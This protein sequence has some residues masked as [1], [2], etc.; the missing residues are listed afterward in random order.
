MRSR[1]SASYGTGTITAVEDY[2]G[3][4]TSERGRCHRLVYGEGDGHP[5]NCP[6]PPVKSGWRQS[7]GGSWHAVD[8]CVRHSPELEDRPR[9]GRRPAA[10]TASYGGPDVRADD[11]DS[12]EGRSRLDAPGR[13][14]SRA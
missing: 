14:G 7:Y 11:F 8:A 13:R 10:G 12:T 3:A 4:W 9:A 1:R 6:A 2:A 5:A